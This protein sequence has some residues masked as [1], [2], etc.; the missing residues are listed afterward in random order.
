MLTGYPGPV[1]KCFCPWSC[2]GGPALTSSPG[3]QAKLVPVSI[4]GDVPLAVE[5]LLLAGQ[6]DQAFDLAAAKWQ[7]EIFGQ[8]AA[9]SVKVRCAGWHIQCSDA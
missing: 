3:H 6:L 7:L 9:S 2:Y 4:A 5:F 1:I 8:L